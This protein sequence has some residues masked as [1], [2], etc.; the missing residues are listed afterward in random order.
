MILHSMFDLL[1]FN[2]FQV[3]RRAER[4]NSRMFRKDRWPAVVH[5]KN[6]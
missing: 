3:V 5:I 4:P 2:N 6:F 1:V